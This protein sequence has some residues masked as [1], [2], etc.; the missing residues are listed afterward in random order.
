MRKKKL[1]KIAWTVLSAF[2][3][4]SMVVSWTLRGY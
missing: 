4:L 3:V 1:M 2:V